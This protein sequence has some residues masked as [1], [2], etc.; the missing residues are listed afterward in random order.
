M[1]GFDQRTLRV[2]WTV[3][4][5]LLAGGLLYLVRQTL[6]VFVLALFLAHLL[7]PLVTWFV[8]LTR[9]RIGRTAAVALVYLAMLALVLVTVIPIGVRIAEEAAGLATRLPQAIQADPLRHLP[10]PSC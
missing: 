8:R 4:L 1:P 5:F 3:F 6:V 2:L 7:D 9:Q 10:R